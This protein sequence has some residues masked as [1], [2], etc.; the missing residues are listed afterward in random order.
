MSF[1]GQE[2]DKRSLVYE[3]KVKVLSYRSA[4]GGDLEFSIRFDDMS[5]MDYQTIDLSETM[6]NLVDQILGSFEWWEDE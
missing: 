1:L 2:I 5:A 6:Q 3:G 4:E